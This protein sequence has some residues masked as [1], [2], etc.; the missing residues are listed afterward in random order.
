M[1]S[2][3]KHFL[4]CQMSLNFSTG[5]SLPAPVG[6]AR[7]NTVEHEPVKQVIPLSYTSLFSLPKQFQHLH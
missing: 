3:K 4:N 1:S 7:G 6:M 5:V 2:L